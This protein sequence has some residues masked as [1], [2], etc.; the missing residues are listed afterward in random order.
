MFP[1]RSP[2]RSIGVSWREV[3][4]RYESS[5]TL[6]EHGAGEALPRGDVEG[7]VTA[8]ANQTQDKK[9][10]QR[11]DA[12]SQKIQRH[13]SEVDLA[14]D[15]ARP[16]LTL[17]EAISPKRKALFLHRP[18]KGR[19]VGKEIRIVLHDRSSIRYT[20]RDGTVIDELVGAQ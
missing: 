14:V 12:I 10:R 6:N 13:L 15:E 4:R 7:H 2:Q 16:P 8:D 9:L 20:K 1:R 11:L 19:K 5:S 18:R 17:T 3:R